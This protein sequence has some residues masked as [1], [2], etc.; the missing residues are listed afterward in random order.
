[1]TMD[2]AERGKLDIGR[3]ISE[4]FQVL[5]RNAVAFLVLALLLSG[6]P[7]GI[8]S[9]MAAPFA[10][11]Q[12]GNLDFDPSR[13]AWIFLGGLVG[14][15]TAAIL[16]GALIFGT[17][18][19]MNGQRPNIGECLATGLRAFLPLIGVS[20]LFALAVVFGFMLLFVPGLMIICAWCVAVPSLVAERTGVFG[21]FNRS[22]DLTRGNRWRIFALLVV[23]WVIAVVISMIV[24][25]I[26]TGAAF[27]TGGLDPV[28][29]A[30]SPARIVG[31]VLSNTLSTAISSTGVAVLYVELRKA[32]EGLGPQWLADIFS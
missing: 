11:V 1:M 31:A 23:A 6:V 17:V 18:Q 22:A 5:G 24:G 32:R 28:A 19:D 21:A 14:L 13:L 26:A 25:A 12:T 2:V 29:L 15:V 20:I 7:A 16:Q 30:R 8:M 4:T 3:V 9:Y 27:A 10:G